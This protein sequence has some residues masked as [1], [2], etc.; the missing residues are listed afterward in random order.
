MK[1][2]KKDEPA[3]MCYCVKCKKKVTMKDPMLEKTKRGGYIYKGQCSECGG[4]CAVITSAS[5]VE[6]KD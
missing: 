2:E 3:V 5:K 4:K 1:K 6:K